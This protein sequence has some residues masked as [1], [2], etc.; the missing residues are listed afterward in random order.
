MPNTHSYT[1]VYCEFYERAITH[2][3][4]LLYINS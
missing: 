4:L 3:K 2:I 1:R